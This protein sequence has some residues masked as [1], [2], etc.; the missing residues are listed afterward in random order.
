VLALT[1]AAGRDHR[2]IP[3]KTNPRQSQP[4]SPGPAEPLE[5]PTALATS[6]EGQ[7]RA[8][9]KS[10]AE[11]FRRQSLFPERELDASRSRYSAISLQ[12]AEVAAP[13]KDSKSVAYEIRTKSAKSGGLE[14][15]GRRERISAPR[16]GAE[17]RRFVREGRGYW[18]FVRARKAAEKVG[19]GRAGGGRATGIQRSLKLV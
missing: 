12:S 11:L 7:G 16:R 14:T 2:N 6:H 5:L 17:V 1:S 4:V 9:R 15:N 8:S 18:A 10:A 19:R 13:K 3:D